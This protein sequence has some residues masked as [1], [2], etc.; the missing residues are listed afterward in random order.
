MSNA[1]AKK[2]ATEPTSWLPVRSLASVSAR[3]A[4]AAFIVFGGGVS[5][6]LQVRH[7]FHRLGLA[8]Q[9]AGHLVQQRQGARAVDG[10]CQRA[11]S[12]ASSLN[13]RAAN[14]MAPKLLARDP[15]QAAP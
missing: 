6:D 4:T 2:W 12:A 15:V 7:I 5:R 8:F 14:D 11:I 3:T 1:Q 13:A 10:A 9:V